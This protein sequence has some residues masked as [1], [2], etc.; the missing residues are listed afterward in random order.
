MR[1]NV[2]SLIWL[3]MSCHL[4]K[5]SDFC[6]RSDVGAGCSSSRTAGGVRAT[7][8]GGDGTVRGVLGFVASCRR[9]VRGT[10]RCVGGMGATVGSRL[11]RG[12]GFGVRVRSPRAL[13]CTFFTLSS[14]ALPFQRA[15]AM[16]LVAS[17]LSVMIA[18]LGVMTMGP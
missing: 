4:W 3:K 2:L 18:A 13:Q 16:T 14:Y 5:A 8:R 1:C 17:F 10:L 12:R 11:M 6:E 7:V 15:T 9:D